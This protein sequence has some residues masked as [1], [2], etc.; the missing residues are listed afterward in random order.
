MALAKAQSPIISTRL[1]QSRLLLAAGIPV[2]LALLGLVMLLHILVGAADIAP[3]DVIQS[4]TAYDADNT[5]HLVIRSVR[6]PR[7]IIGITVG[8]ALAIA[9]AMIQG[10]T[11]NR[12]AD[13]GLLGIESGAVVA[14]VLAVYFLNVTSASHY[15]WFGF[16]GAA[17]TGIVVYSLGSMG[18]RGA[19][20][21]KLVIAGAALTS[22]IGSVTTTILIFSQQTT[23]QIRFWLAG[24]IAGRDFTVYLQVLPYFIVGFGLAFVLARQ[25]TTLSMG[26]DVARG[27]GQNTLL[28]QGLAA[29]S[30]ILLAGASAAISGAIGFIGLVIPHIT[31]YLVG[32]DYRWVLPYSAILGAMLLVGADI[33]ARVIV[34]PIE[35]PVGIMTALIGAP[36]F[37]YLA[38]SKVQA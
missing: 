30:I 22:L 6:F 29:V 10:V 4:F 2:A 15:A 18:R 33:A 8:A 35:L 24:S 34:R 31:R 14:V 27:L 21:A 38:R 32:V 23:E 37:V 13:P 1:I 25:I 26:E 5:S 12:L 16:T 3:P 17:I 20:P 28:I 11:R 7:V 36:L 19:T 9:G